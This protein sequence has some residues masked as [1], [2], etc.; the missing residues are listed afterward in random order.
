M[1]KP[2]AVQ[3]KGKLCTPSKLSD[4][5]LRVLVVEAIDRMERLDNLA[6]A[7]GVEVEGWRTA[8]A[9]SKTDIRGLCQPEEVSQDEPAQPALQTMGGYTGALHPNSRAV[10]H[11][12][13]M[14]REQLLKELRA[15]HERL[16]Q[17]RSLVLGMAAVVDAL[18]ET[19]NESGVSALV[20]EGNNERAGPASLR[21][22]VFPDTTFTRGNVQAVQAPFVY[23]RHVEQ[24]G[25][26]LLRLSM[27][28]L[29]A[30]NRTLKAGEPVW[31]TLNA[32][33]E[34]VKAGRDS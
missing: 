18:G 20:I 2:F 33:G 15:H 28:K 34:V 1:K 8:A 4:T 11:V 7:L 16:R 26:K 22:D 32:I 25:E 23:V 12:S 6:H 17:L 9:V 10:V 21:Q 24:E 27:D 14:S 30:G 19:F 13:E 31:M 5:D 3:F 29:C